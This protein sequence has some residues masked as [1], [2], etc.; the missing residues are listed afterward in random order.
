MLALS[1]RQL[2]RKDGSFSASTSLALYQEAIHQLL[3][4]LHNKDVAVVASCV[5]LCV[6]E[7]QSCRCGSLLDV[8][9]LT[10]DQ[11][12]RRLGGGI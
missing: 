12:R 1:A 6:L 11:A 2:E 9:L 5:I 8:V 4:E 3:P 10:L 7:M